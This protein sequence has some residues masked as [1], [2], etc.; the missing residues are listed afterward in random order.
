[1]L[2]SKRPFSAHYFFYFETP[3]FSKIKSWAVRPWCAQQFFYSAHDPYIPTPDHFCSVVGGFWKI[4]KMKFWNRLLTGWS[5]YDLRGREGGY[6]ELKGSYRIFKK[7]I[8]VEFVLHPPPPGR[9]LKRLSKKQCIIEF[10]ITKKTIFGN[11][12]LTRG[13]VLR[14]NPTLQHYFFF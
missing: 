12:S 9:D 8:T 3:I 1:M 11:R 5:I 7:C 2:W 10:W 4:T 14:T 6:S 13:G